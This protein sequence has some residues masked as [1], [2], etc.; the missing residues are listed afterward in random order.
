[1]TIA[2]KTQTLVAALTDFTTKVESG[3]SRGGNLQSTLVGL[4]GQV[5]YVSLSGE[6]FSF[7]VGNSVTKILVALTKTELGNYQLFN[8][9]MDIVDM[10]D[11]VVWRWNGNAYV[12]V[13][14]FIT[15]LPAGRLF[16]DNAH[17][18]LYA[19]LASGTFT[20]IT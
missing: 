16:F 17:S 1:M 19:T 11:L 10:V 5:P 8:S 13:G 18:T 7:T 20:K 9:G 2:T 6:P 3:L 14:S 15:A 12:N 4:K